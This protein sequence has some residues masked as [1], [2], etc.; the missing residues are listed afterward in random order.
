MGVLRHDT[1]K[2]APDV[3]L[4]Y[5]CSAFTQVLKSHG[6]DDRYLVLL[7][8]PYAN[9]SDK[10]MVFCDFLGRARALKAINSWYISP[11]AR[12]GNEPAYFNVSFWSLGF[13]GLG[14]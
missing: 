5:P 7:I 11:K 3:D 10:F 6:K 9:L 8:G 2:R 12:V 1:E 14:K 4:K 13:F